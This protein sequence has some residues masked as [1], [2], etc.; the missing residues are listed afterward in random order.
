LRR[1]YCTGDQ[2][3]TVDQVREGLTNLD[4]VERC[5]LVVEE[6]VVGAEVICVD[7]NL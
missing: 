5:G 1:A 7:A 6:Q 4:I 3:I 2:T